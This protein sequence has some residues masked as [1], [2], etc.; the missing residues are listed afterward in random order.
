MQ[1]SY[2]FHHPGVTDRGIT[3]GM[4]EDIVVGWEGLRRINSL[5]PLL[6]D[7]S[8]NDQYGLLGGG[9]A[10]SLGGSWLLMWLWLQA[11]VMREDGGLCSP[12]WAV[13]GP[14]EDV[15]GSSALCAHQP[16]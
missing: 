6:Y 1:L 8:L 7:M 14:G 16:A 9:G 13:A 15:S 2:T 4:D 11:L 5:T 3:L 12:C 10:L